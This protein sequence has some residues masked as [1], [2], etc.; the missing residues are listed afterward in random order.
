M[1]TVLEIEHTE[2]HLR[3]TQ[4][5]L[6]DLISCHPF[7]CACRTGQASMDLLK[8]FLVQ[9][10][11]Y[12]GYFTRYLCA[13]MANLRSNDHIRDLAQNLFEELG[14]SENSQIPHFLLYGQMLEEFGLNPQEEKPT[15]GTLLLID[16]MFSHCRQVDPTIGLGALCLGAEG[17]VPPMYQDLVAGFRAQGVSEKTLQFFYLH[18]SCD[19]DHALTLNRL[20]LELIDEEPECLARIVTAG[21][22]LVSARMVFFDDIIGAGDSLEQGEITH[23]HFRTGGNYGNAYGTRRP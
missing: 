1:S 22:T 3:R 10:G 14:F 20:M 2:S 5:Q 18:I 6:V 21:R 9:Q 23:H 17:L 15:R 12:S 13:L 8:R 19:D 4:K 7:M 11:I 16:N